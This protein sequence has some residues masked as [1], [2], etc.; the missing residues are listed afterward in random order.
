MMQMPVTPLPAAPAADG[1][2]LGAGAT[3]GE[4]EAAPPTL[5]ANLL[6]ALQAADAPHGETALARQLLLVDPEPEI[7]AG[8]LPAEA[9]AEGAPLATMVLPQILVPTLIADDAMSIPQAPADADAMSIGEAPAA[10]RPLVAGGQGVEVETEATPTLATAS[11]PTMTSTE[12]PP[13]H[14]PGALPTETTTPT[15]STTPAN[16]A[17]PASPAP[18]NAALAQVPT[19]AAATTAAA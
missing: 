11:L 4:G 10:P 6:T 14:G 13:T 19:P 18:A 7:E 17:T 15:T 1:A 2:L 12:P 9:P 3:G 5:F 8:N 16:P